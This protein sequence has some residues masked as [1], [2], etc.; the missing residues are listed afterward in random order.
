ML[1][2]P[3]QWLRSLRGSMASQ[4]AVWVCAAVLTVAGLALAIGR[5]AESHL[6]AD[7]ER[8]AAGWARH[9]GTTVPDIDLVFMGDVPSPQAQDR[10]VALRGT[11]G[12]F[13]FKLYDPRGSLLL[14][15][16]SVGTPPRPEDIHT[17][18]AER[19]RQA[20]STGQVLSA[21]KKGDGREYPEVY[22]GPLCRCAMVPWS[23]ASSRWTWTRPNSPPPP[24]RPSAVPP[25]WPAPP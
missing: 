21:L 8:T 20:G 23:S 22:S 4:A 24:R 17:D 25:P 19:A 18:D 5:L 3:R 6:Q 7:A 2:H 15:S 12:L 13:R 1:S 11:A 10:L 9:V 14:Q 16:E